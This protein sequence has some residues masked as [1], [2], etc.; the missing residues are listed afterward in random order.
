MLEIPPWTEYA[1]IGVMR[2]GVIVGGIVYH[3][4]RPQ[5]GDIQISVAATSARWLT[6]GVLRAIH[7][8]PFVQLECARVTARTRKNNKRARSALERLGFRMEGMQ[9]KAMQG[10]DAVLYGLLASECKHL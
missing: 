6:R 3:D 4:Y 8:Y 9:R 2:D 10:R 5:D 7:R 1:A